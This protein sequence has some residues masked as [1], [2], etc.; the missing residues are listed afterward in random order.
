MS[1]L[2]YNGS[3]MVAMKGDNC[4]S[5]ATDKRFGIQGQ[6]ISIEFPKVFQMGPHLYVG[7]PGL[8]T[9]TQTVVE[10]LNFR[11]NLYELKE[12]RRIS[13]KVFASM[14]S[15][16]LY[17]KRFGPFFVEPVIAGLDPITAEPYVCNMDL[18]GCINEPED[19]VVGGT[20]SAQLFGM[21]EALWEPKLK[22]DDLFETT[23]QA[24]IN[25]FDRDAMSGW[26]ATVYI[27]EKDKITV[28]DL[29]TR[30]D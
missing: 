23:S 19:F 29:K 26:G 3:A 27:I 15:N 24:L 1:I 11:K 14:V 12:N 16:L 9:D 21:C 5:I 10:K 2:S 30:M 17:E 20:A 7:L 4:V 6:T 28:K 8:A 13:P 25:A 18:I 22:P